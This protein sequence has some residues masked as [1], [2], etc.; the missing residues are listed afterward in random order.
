MSSLLMMM[1]LKIFLWIK[2]QVPMTNITPSSGTRWST[3]RLFPLRPTLNNKRIKRKLR[4]LLLMPLLRR[5]V[6]PN[7]IKKRPPKKLRS[8]WKLKRNKKWLR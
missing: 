3:L 5:N 2:T 8:K 4:E 7:K 6:K 1:I